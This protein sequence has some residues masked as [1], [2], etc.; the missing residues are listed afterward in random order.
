MGEID[1]VLAR[2][3]LPCEVALERLGLA[4]AGRIGGAAGYFR[5]SA[6][7]TG[8]ASLPHWTT[9]QP[10]PGQWKHDRD[11]SW[12]ARDPTTV[13]SASRRARAFVPCGRG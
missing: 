10:K 3:R 13:G 7:L 4:P 11:I 5:R 1:S 9:A 12:I 6:H 2:M 8:S